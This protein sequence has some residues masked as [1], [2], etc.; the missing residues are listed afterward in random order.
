MPRGIGSNVRLKIAILLAA[1]L[2]A[3]AA[4]RAADATLFRLFLIDGTAMVSYGEYARVDDRV[5]FSMPVG[6][7]PDQPRLHV[8]TIPAGLVDWPRT[9]KYADSARYQR[10]AETRGEEDFARLSNE[11]AVVLNE[12]ALSTD[13]PRALALAEEARRVLAAW[14]QAHFG[15]RG[16]D[17]R[18]IV[19]LV[20]ESISSLRAAEGATTFELSLVATA[21]PPELEPVLGMP[22]A[23]QQLDQIHRVV[24]MT[25]RA[26]E[27]VALL[28]SALAIL[29]E[30]DASINPAEIETLRRSAESLIREELA[31]DARYSLLSDRLITQA[32][33][34]AGR[35]SISDVQRVLARIPKED[36]KLGR[37]R[38]ELVQ[39]LRATIE[40]RLEDARELRLLRDRW[41]LRQGLYRDY[42]RSV[43]SQLLQL[44]K[45][46]PLLEA[47]RNLEGP[48][49]DTLQTLRTRLRGG[50]ER[51]Q[52][53]RTPE[54]LRVTHDLLIGAWRFAESAA[55][56]RHEAITAADIDTAWEASS[57]AAGAL[58][59]LSRAQQQLRELLEPPRL[60]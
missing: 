3:P 8:V 6:G 9:E 53:L 57:A 36:E 33:R 49:P 32:T 5:I 56:A 11:V 27:R 14:P 40:R 25:S 26:S 35:A 42:Q 28:H 34:A 30:P 55:Q 19:S 59:M 44:V 16:A 10:Y 52:R 22:S 4:A 47:I 37:Q 2:L 58:M 38:P 54:D 51:L 50:A 17:V 48:S 29:G 1:C 21:M 15:Y 20:D 24:S 39:A 12:I 43:G 46:Q 45:A 41:T 13:R 23:R 60:Q 31:V 18:E 7:P